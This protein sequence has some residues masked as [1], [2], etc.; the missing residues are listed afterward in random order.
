MKKVAFCFLIYDSI[1]H[2]EL[3]NLFFSDVDPSRY[4]IYIHYKTDKPLKFFERYKLK[5]CIPTKYCDMT[6]VLA[7][8]ILFREAYQD[9]E[10]YK[11]VILSGS[12]IPLKSFDHVY[13][14]LT[15]DHY[16]YFNVCPQSQCFPNCDSLLS[17]MEKKYISK[18]HNWFILNRKLVKNLCFD[19]DEIVKKL[20]QKIYAPEEYFY[21]TYIKILN[22]E[23]EI[24]TTEN[25]SNGATTFTNW[26]GMDYK[27]VSERS[28]KNYSHISHE[29]I[30]YLLGSKCLFGR[31]FNKEC[32]SSLFIPEYIKCVS[33][34]NTS[35]S[36]RPS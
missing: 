24:R 36:T 32:F 27:Y 25:E 23:D 19:K 4:S 9:E 35:I 16:G 3:W 22:L 15:L 12:C 33:T 18:A 13:N 7:Y 17:V 8:N 21:Y 6:I 34:E 30:L 10:N 31:K 11:F 2:E 14:K 1:H 5:Q 20:Y 29:E 28:I 26:Q